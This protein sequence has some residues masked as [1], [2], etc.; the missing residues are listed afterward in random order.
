MKVGVISS[1]SLLF[2]AFYFFLRSKSLLVK[3]N[4]YE[5]KNQ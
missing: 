3:I 4:L 1:A 2:V 5:Q